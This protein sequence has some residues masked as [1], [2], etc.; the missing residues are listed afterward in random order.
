MIDQ[1]H[2]DKVILDG[3]PY[4]RR[5]CTLA[6]LGCCSIVNQWRYDSRAGYPTYV[7]A[8]SEQVREAAARGRKNRVR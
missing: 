6:I 7:A 1:E 4:G 3:C 5:T 2:L 8:Y